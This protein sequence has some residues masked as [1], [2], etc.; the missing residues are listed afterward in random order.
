MLYLKLL[1]D[2]THKDGTF[3]CSEYGEV[4]QN[5]MCIFHV[6][7]KCFSGTLTIWRIQTISCYGH[8]VIC[9]EFFPGDFI[10][11]RV[12]MLTCLLQ[13]PSAKADYPLNPAQTLV[14]D[15]AKLGCQDQGASCYAEKH[16]SWEPSMRRSGSIFRAGASVLTFSIIF[17][18]TL[19]G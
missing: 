18:L 10:V 5:W 4:K 6:I 13:V 9:D 15:G 2:K 1:L 11:L 12:H 19:I 14:R 17:K 7:V 3:S 16:V 8:S